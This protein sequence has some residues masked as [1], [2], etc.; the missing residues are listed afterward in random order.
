LVVDSKAE[1]LVLEADN[2]VA[3]SVDEAAL[4]VLEDVEVLE[5]EDLVLNRHHHLDLDK[6]LV[7]LHLEGPEL[8]VPVL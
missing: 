6:V 3:G 5:G 2:K 1:E 8:S 4:V 7:G